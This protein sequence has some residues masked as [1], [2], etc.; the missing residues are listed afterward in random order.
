MA[1]DVKIYCSIVIKILIIISVILG[2]TLSYLYGH[3]VGAQNLL[4]FTLQSNIW[5]AAFDLIMVVLM[6]NSFKTHRFKYSKAIHIFQQV[7]TVCITITGVIFCFVLVPGYYADKSSAPINFEPFSASSIL[8]HMVVPVLAVFDF[9]MFTRKVEFKYKDSLYA[10]IPNFAYLAFAG[11]GYAANWDFGEGKNYPYFFLNYGS[12]AGMFGFSDQM[13][14]FMG[15]FYWMIIIFIFAMSVSLLYIKL[16][17][18][19]D[20]RNLFKMRLKET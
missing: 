10:L 8:L 15:S 19:I 5:I 11:I 18:V 1:K 6:I 4:Y 14:Y 12:P 17:K 16:I 2:F 3:G 9:L 7:F 20:K 13:P